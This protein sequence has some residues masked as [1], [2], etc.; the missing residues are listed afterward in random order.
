MCIGLAVVVRQLRCESKSKNAPSRHT[1]YQDLDRAVCTRN[2]DVF[3]LISG[4]TRR[5]RGSG[6]SLPDPDQ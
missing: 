3:H 5:P 6:P 2:H 1:P 4:R